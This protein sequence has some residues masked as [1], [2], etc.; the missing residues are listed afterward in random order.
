M[1]RQWERKISKDITRHL[2][3]HG[4][5]VYTTEQGYRKE[6]I[7]VSPGIPDLFVF[8]PPTGR[9]TFAELKTEKAKMNVAQQR[10]REYCIAT[11]TPWQLWRSVKD[12]NV[13]LKLVDDGPIYSEA[14]D[15]GRRVNRRR[16]ARGLP[17]VER[18]TYPLPAGK[19]AMY[20]AYR[21]ER[22]MRE[23]NEWGREV[24]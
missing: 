11:D 12:A 8:H 5:K 19:L 20:N 9:F 14:G 13:W 21:K 2:T 7:R 3:G 1:A 22:G 15:P 4:C 10:F 16:R 18:T 24:E 6:G 17:P 23:I